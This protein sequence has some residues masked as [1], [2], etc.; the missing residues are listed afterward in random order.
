[1]AAPTKLQ[2][3]VLTCQHGAVHTWHF[4]DIEAARL[5]VRFLAFPD[6]SAS[7]AYVAE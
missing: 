2:R 5:N 1:M 7:P 4:G 3:E 6:I